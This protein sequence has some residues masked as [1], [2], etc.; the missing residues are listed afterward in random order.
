LTTI[1]FSAGSM[2]DIE[3]QF[4]NPRLL[5][6]FINNEGGANT[7]HN[8]PVPVQLAALSDVRQI[9]S[10]GYN[11]GIYI[12]A[13]NTGIYTVDSSGTSQFVSSIPYSALPV[14]ICENLQYQVTITDGENAY[15]YSQ[16]TDKFQ[17][18]NDGSIAGFDLKNPN[19][20][21]VLNSFTIISDADSNMWQVSGA[22][23]ALSWNA[24]DKQQIESVATQLVG[25]CSFKNN[26]IIVGA[27]AV[28]RWVPSVEA[29]EYMFPF[30]RDDNFRTDYGAAGSGLI[31]SDIDEVT[32]LSSDYRAIV[33]DHSG[34]TTVSTPGMS[35][36]WESQYADEIGTAMASFFSYKGLYF[37]QYT[38]SDR[39]WVYCMDTQKW[40]ETT[41]LFLGADGAVVKIDGVYN[42]TDQQDG[43]RRLVEIITPD[44]RFNDGA[45]SYRSVLNAVRASIIQG[46]SQKTQPDYLEL[47]ISCDGLKWGNSVK[48]VIGKTGE[49]VAKTQWR[50]SMAANQ[51]GFRLRYYGDQEFILYQLDGIFNPPVQVMEK[52]T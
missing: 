40:C 2:P 22:N 47:S 24:S 29:N 38:F 41:E 32:F 16:K 3:T 31:T 17:Q 15:V 7:V 14:T 9:F 18:L 13:T 20:C 37:I 5:N 45:N 30:Q 1:P 35:A 36:I 44:L 46:R 43:Y 28:E 4:E 23:N 11:G 42:L 8:F 25:V 39:G 6:A 10:S 34:T 52:P 48:S 21:T 26:L 12:V 50:L 27:D 51:F 49:R 19:S 33:I